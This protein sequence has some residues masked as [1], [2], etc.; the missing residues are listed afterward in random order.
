MDF[1]V[2][3]GA[4]TRPRIYV[5]VTL[6][7]LPSHLPPIVPRTITPSQAYATGSSEH[8]RPPTAV[9]TAQQIQLRYERHSCVRVSYHTRDETIRQFV[10]IRSRR[11]SMGGC[12]LESS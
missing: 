12:S 2:L 5:T 9:L 10:V 6:F 1:F 7:R 4:A 3:R 8:A 11:T